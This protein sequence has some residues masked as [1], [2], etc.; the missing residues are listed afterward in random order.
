M[1]E[2][3]EQNDQQEMVNRIYGYTADM[4][5]NQKKTVEET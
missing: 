1:E 4:L 3:R 5:F 2:N